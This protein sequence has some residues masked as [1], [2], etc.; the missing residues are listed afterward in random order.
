MQLDARFRLKPLWKIRSRLHLNVSTLRVV[1]ITD[2]LSS[3][4]MAGYVLG[5]IELVIEY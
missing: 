2:R 4:K 5:S 1:H 3:W